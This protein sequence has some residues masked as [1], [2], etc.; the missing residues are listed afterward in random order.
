[1]VVKNVAGFDL[2]RLMTGSWGTLGVIT[3][4][5][6][7]LYALPATDR[8]FSVA[9]DG[10]EKETA[11]LIHAIVTSPVIPYALQLLSRSAAR[12]L[13]LGDNPVCVIR[14]GGN[15]AVV[16]AQLIALSKVPRPEEDESDLWVRLRELEA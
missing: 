16:D 2:S 8:T 15:E 13:G 3:E 7:R 4:V 1:K 10:G 5:T 14:L 11:A 6:L 9:L 12:A